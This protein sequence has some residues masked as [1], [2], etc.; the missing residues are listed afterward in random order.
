MAEAFE[1]FDA[2]LAP[3]APTVAFPHDHKPFASRKLKTGDGAIIPYPAMLNWI[4]LAT[5]CHLPVTTI[6]AGLAASGLP[7]GAQIIGPHGAD[8][9]TLSI[10]QAIDEALGGYVAPPPG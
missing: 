2:I 8:S 4:A 3:V 5:A 9:R 6:P 1:A 7:V 10:A